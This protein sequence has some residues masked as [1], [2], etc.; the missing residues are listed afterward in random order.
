MCGRITLTLSLEE[1]ADRYNVAEKIEWTPRYNIAPQQPVPVIINDGRNHLELFRWG[2][3]PFWAEDPA[4]GNRLINARAETV[5]S[6]PSFRHSFRRQRCL[7]LAD[8][9]YEWKKEG[10]KKRPF[11]FLLH[12]Q[13]IFGFAGLWDAWKN[14]E[15]KVIR[16]CTIITINSNELV[17]HVHDRM[18]VILPRDKEELWL[19]PLRTDVPELKSVL[20][21]YPADLMEFYEVSAYVNSITHDDPECIKPLPGQQILF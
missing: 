1:V 3:I 21:P 6:K 17:S 10:N 8:G 14:P 20:L 18:P 12:S 2:L 19:D 7:I 5:E 4:V 15:G 13:E 16:T 9:F 11:H